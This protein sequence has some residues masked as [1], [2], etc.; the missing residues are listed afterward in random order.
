[1]GPIV[2]PLLIYELHRLLRAALLQKLLWIVIG[3]H[4][5]SL[6]T[7]GLIPIEL[8][9]VIMVCD[10]NG[11]VGAPTEISR[12]LLEAALQI[13]LRVCARIAHRHIILLA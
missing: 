4:R 13:T 2:G 3:V 5:E 6:N 12:E 10:C 8:L 11:G 1:M 7:I 9:I